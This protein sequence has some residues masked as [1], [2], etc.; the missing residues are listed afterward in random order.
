[1]VAEAPKARRTSWKWEMVDEKAATKAGLTLVI[2]NKEK[3]DE[4]L[5]EKRENETELTENGIRYF[6]HK[7]Y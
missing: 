3:I 4:L 5:K 1:V 7:E 2:P 6:I